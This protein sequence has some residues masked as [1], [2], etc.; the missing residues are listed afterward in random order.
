[1][2]HAAQRADEDDHAVN[3]QTRRTENRW[4]TDSLAANANGFA[5]YSKAAAVAAYLRQLNARAPF[6]PRQ[7]CRKAKNKAKVDVIFE[8]RER[9]RERVSQYTHRT[10][11][12]RIA[13]IGTTYLRTRR[14]SA[15]RTQQS[16]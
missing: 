11:S 13:T 3:T 8:Q 4:P 1:V 10:R 16:E 14:A 9:E 5:G 2:T 7:I 6:E 15:E 12:E